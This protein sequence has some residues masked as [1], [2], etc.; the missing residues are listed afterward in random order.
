MGTHQQTH[1]HTNTHTH[2]HT[3]RHTDTQTHTHTH[4]HTQTHRH[5]DTHTHTHTHRHT[6]TQTHTDTHRHTHRHTDTHRHTQTHTQTHTHRHTHRHTDTQ[7]HTDTHRHTDTQTQDIEVKLD[8]DFTEFVLRKLKLKTEEL[9]VLV[10]YIPT[11][12]QERDK[13]YDTNYRGAIELLNKVTQIAH[14]RGNRLLILGDF[15]L[16]KIDWEEL[17]PH[18]EA[19]SWEA[20]FLDCVQENLLFQHVR[21]PTRERG[22]DRPSRLDLV[23]TTN[24]LEIE[25]MKYRTPLF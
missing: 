4:T 25:G 24:E 14:N 20:R 22:T 11:R 5:T 16:R 19:D 12:R 9:I 23:F 21:Q 3:H 18:A 6:D 10:M 2:T 1:T 8:L 17:N 13:E 7:T 15:N